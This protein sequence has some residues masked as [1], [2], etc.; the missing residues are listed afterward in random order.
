MPDLSTPFSSRMKKHFSVFIFLSLTVLFFSASFS[1]P[2]FW[3]DYF[4]IQGNP[5][6]SDW[7]SIPDAFWDQ[8]ITSGGV[9]DLESQIY[10][11][12]RTIYF[13]VVVCLFGKNPVLFHALSVGLHWIVSFFLYRG[14]RSLIP[15]RQTAALF[16]ASI[17]LFHPIHLESI[18][19]VFGCGDLWGSLF[20][21]WVYEKWIRAPILSWELIFASAAGL[22]SAM[23]FKEIFVT[24]PLLLTLLC[25]KKARQSPGKTVFLNAASLLYFLQ[26]WFVVHRWDQSDLGLS[27]D[28]HVLR[29]FQTFFFYLKLFFCPVGLS[30]VYP[31]PAPILSADTVLCLLGLAL[32]LGAGIG[33]WFHG[34]SGVLLGFLVCVISMLPILNVVSINTFVNDRL[35]YFPSVIL[36]LLGFSAWSAA[37]L[38]R[39]MFFRLTGIGLAIWIY[40]IGYQRNQEW[41]TSS[42]IWEQAWEKTGSPLSLWNMAMAMMQEGRFQEAAAFFQ[43]RPVEL[44]INYHPYY[45]RFLATASGRAGLHGDFW[46]Y[47]EA[48]LKSDLGP[49][50]EHFLSPEEWKAFAEEVQ[51]ISSPMA[52]KILENLKERRPEIFKN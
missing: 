32:F 23:L 9:N 13:I 8:K 26:R 30:Q 49:Y 12:F 36:V 43:K 33:L 25:W 31:V 37:P 10:R 17:F 14:M 42:K 15:E 45:H 19:S 35:F 18:N 5:Y 47:Y 52:Q 4:V 1:L 24:T 28:G 38:E 7:G 16:F 41:K 2:F 20:F 48:M 50:G 3:D 21:I 44:P 22:Y 39:R 51:T 34:R 6:L 27:L 11:P 40:G 46:A 29:I